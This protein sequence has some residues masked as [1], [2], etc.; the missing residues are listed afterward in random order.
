[1]GMSLSLALSLGGIVA[2]LGGLVASIVA[3]GADGT[4]ATLQITGTLA[5]SLPARG[6][7]GTTATVEVA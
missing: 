1:M 3:R 2:P 7:D 4:T 5:A 6:A